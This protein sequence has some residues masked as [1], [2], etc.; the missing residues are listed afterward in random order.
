MLDR[1]ARETDSVVNFED[2]AGYSLRLDQLRLRAEQYYHHGPFCLF[3]KFQN[4]NVGCAENKEKSKRIAGK[5]RTPFWGCCPYGVWDLAYPVV[6]QETIAGIFY[7]GSF[8]EAQPLEAVNGR[9]YTG[10]ALPTI[11]DSLRSSLLERGR[12]LSEYFLLTLQDLERDGRLPS[13]VRGEEAYMELTEQFLAANYHEPVN[14]QAFASRLGLHPNYLGARIRRATGKSFSTLLREYRVE[15]AE[16]LLRSTA[17]PITE[18]AFQ[19]G[20]TDSN[21]FST[22]F[23]RARGLSPRRYREM[24][25]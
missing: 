6:F 12:F 3:A 22:V 4:R 13:L 9:S 18:I 17:R 25:A 21:Y 1:V 14:L 2:L 20:F 24:V 8:R 19:C 11:T 16:V 15:R 23:R 7:L 5:V 10:P